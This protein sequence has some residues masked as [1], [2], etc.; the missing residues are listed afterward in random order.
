VSRRGGGSPQRPLLR[1]GGV[2]SPLQR[3]S[4]VGPDILRRG[5]GPDPR[6]RVLSI[7]RRAHH[8][9]VMAGLDRR[10][11]LPNRVPDRFRRARGLDCVQ[12]RR[13]CGV[14]L[15]RSGSEWFRFREIGLLRRQLAFERERAEI[16]GELSRRRPRAGNDFAEPAAWNLQR[17]RLGEFRTRGVG[18]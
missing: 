11:L 17:R 9:S 8:R 7:R 16:A 14:L 5:A 4:E 1:L 12:R 18:V 13:A 3:G 2:P 6:R 10:H 15:F